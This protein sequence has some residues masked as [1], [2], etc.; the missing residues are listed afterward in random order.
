MII[1]KRKLSDEKGKFYPRTISEYLETE[2][3]K[4]LIFNDQMLQIKVK[5]NFNQVNSSF[6]DSRYMYCHTAIFNRFLKKPNNN[7]NYS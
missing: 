6:I 1:K 4:I 5:R 3:L 7:I 2:P